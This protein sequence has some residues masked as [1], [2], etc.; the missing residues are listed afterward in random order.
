ML[1]R[2]QKKNCDILK[3]SAKKI[4]KYTHFCRSDLNLGHTIIRIFKSV[5]ARD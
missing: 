3:G 5:S 4:Q 1:L 2:K